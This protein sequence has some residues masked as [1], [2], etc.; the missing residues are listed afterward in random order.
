MP[1]PVPVSAA[2]VDGVDV[3]VDGCDDVRFLNPLL[4]FLS[5]APPSPPGSHSHLASLNDSRFQK[6]SINLQSL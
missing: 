2:D 1:S 4:Q 3:D 5:C 6:Q